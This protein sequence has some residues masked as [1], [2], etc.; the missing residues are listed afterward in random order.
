MLL[1]LPSLMTPSMVESG[2]HLSPPPFTVIVYVVPFGIEGV[3]LFPALLSCLI[4]P[5][6]HTHYNIPCF[7]NRHHHSQIPPSLHSQNTPAVCMT[8]PF[9]SGP[10]HGARLQSVLN[11]HP[12]V[13]K[14]VVHR[15]VHQPHMCRARISTRTSKQTMTRRMASS[16]SRNLELARTTVIRLMGARV[17]TTAH[18]I[19][20][21][22]QHPH[23][24]PGHEPEPPISSIATTLKCC[25]LPDCAPYPPPFS[26]LYRLN[27]LG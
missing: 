19:A 17:T 22:R 27:S 21:A 1:C 16:S 12:A 7:S 3:P 5:K 10:S 11:D 24:S 4:I 18:I 23:K 6:A 8:I 20:I 9:T 13:N 15:T 2:D 25:C 14:L 26:A